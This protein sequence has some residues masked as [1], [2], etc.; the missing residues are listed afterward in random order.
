MR[1]IILSDGSRVTLNA[2]SMLK[3]PVVFTDSIRE[4]YVEGEAL[5]EVKED[6]GKPFIVNGKDFSV[7]VLGTIFNVMSYDEEPMSLVTLLKGKVKTSS[8]NT[9]VILKSGEQASI[10]VYKRQWCNLPIFFRRI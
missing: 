1:S 3:Y 10:D 9:A 4:V 5:F 6:H 7:N 2:K 8:G